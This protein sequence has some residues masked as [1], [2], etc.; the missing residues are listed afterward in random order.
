MRER[1]GVSFIRTLTLFT[2][3]PPHDLITSYPLGLE[4]KTNW[5]GHKQQGKEIECDSGLAVSFLRASV[6]LLYSGDTEAAL[7][8]F[9]LW[10]AIK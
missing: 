4:F 5:G 7:L 9:D 10:E 8:A 1:S 2:K 6:L 3:A